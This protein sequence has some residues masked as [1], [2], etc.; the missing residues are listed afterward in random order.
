MNIDN[1]DAFMNDNEEHRDIYDNLT[2]IDYTIYRSQNYDK[3][4]YHIKWYASPTVF[5][6]RLLDMRI[7][8][9]HIS[10]ISD[11]IHYEKIEEYMIECD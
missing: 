8:L 10:D 1:A 6:R 4:C 9:S 11:V 7:G 3:Y 5:H 2:F